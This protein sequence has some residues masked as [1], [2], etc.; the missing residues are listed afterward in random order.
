MAR[1]AQRPSERLC[2]GPQDLLCSGLVALCAAALYLC[3]LS[4]SYVF[5]GLARAMPIDVGRLRELFNGNYLLYGFVGRCFHGLMWGLGFSDLAVISLQRMDALIGAGGLSLYWLTLRLMGADRFL[6]TAW[7]AV[8]GLSLGYWIWSTE[9]ENYIF[10]T[11]LLNANFLALVYHARGGRIPPVALGALHALAVLGHIVNVLFGFVTAS[12]LLSADGR[13]RRPLLRYAA[14]L[15]IGVA[16]AYGLSLALIV[17]PASL[18]EAVRWFLGSAGTSE[19]LHWHGV[20]SLSGLRQWTA[21]TLNILISFRSEGLSSSG[22]SFLEIALWGAKLILALAAVALV[23]KARQLT[24]LHRAVARACCVW[25]AAYALV[26]TH[27][28]PYTMVYRVSDL[29]P[30][31]TLLFLGAESSGA[32]PAWRRGGAALL[33]VLLGAGNFALEIHP[34]SLAANNPHLGRMEFLKAHTSEGDWI[35]GDG[36]ADE[37]YIPYFAQRRPLVIGRYRQRPEEL[38]HLIGALLAGDQAVHVTS[39]VLADE[40]W[41]GYFRRYELKRL[42]R[43]RNGFEFYRLGPYAAN[44]P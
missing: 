37:L 11:F 2:L 23:C 29:V 32:P 10:S 4:K 34:R 21:M 40:F 16:A 33:A 26:F 22:L 44:A 12:F 41:G 36:G 1:M 30:I 20:Y 28:E 27:W 6:A 5:E 15:V 13:S 9:A 42:A 39:R 43:D 18:G 3:F 19:G 25:L 38:A 8:L 31:V 35:A 24:E 7:S 17:R 14:A